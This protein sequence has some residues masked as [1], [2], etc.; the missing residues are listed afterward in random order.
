MWWLLTFA[1]VGLA[2]RTLAAGYCSTNTFPTNTTWMQFT[3]EPVSSEY[4]FQD[5]FKSI[6]CCVKGYRSIEWWV[7]LVEHKLAELWESYLVFRSRIAV[8]MWN[9]FGEQCTGVGGVVGEK[10][11]KIFV[12][13]IRNGN[14]YLQSLSV[15]NYRCVHILVL[16]LV[17]YPSWNFKSESGLFFT[18]VASAIDRSSGKYVIWCTL[19]LGVLILRM[20][21]I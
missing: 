6:H 12:H 3:K 19:K 8:D 4:G 21:A 11:A 15:S 13:C 5:K 16:H 10:S 1:L 7:L 18:C 9:V 2:P 14:S 20:L 17:Y